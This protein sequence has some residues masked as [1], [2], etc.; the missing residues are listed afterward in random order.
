MKTILRSLT[1]AF[2]CVALVA[3]QAVAQPAAPKKPPAA[4]KK[5]QKKADKKDEKVAAEPAVVP[6]AEALTGEAKEAY[7]SGKL[8]YADGDYA[9]AKLK[10]E[11]AHELAQDPRLLW[12]MAAAEKQQRRYDRVLALV[13]RYLAEGGDKLTDA[14]RQ[15]AKSLVDMVRALVSEVT[16]SVNE[17]GAEVSVDG[18][19]IGESP[20]AAPL[21][22][23]QGERTFKVTKPGFR[24]FA[25]TQNLQGGTKLA[26]EVV[27]EPQLRE[28][29]LRV[30]A[31]VGD[32]IRIDGKVVGKGQWEGKLASGTHTL[33]VSGKGKRDHQTEIVI[34]DDQLRSERVT[35]E[36]VPK[37][38][39]PERDRDDSSGTWMFVSGGAA[40]AVGIGIAAYF[41]FRPEGETRTERASGTIP[42]NYVPLRF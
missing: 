40:L 42:P 10:F 13:E 24:P 27:L 19:K 17:P 2:L 8:L 5:D 35:L 20:L 4:A 7:E 11:R 26:L 15:E 1:A 6:L 34:E 29:R 32:T 30:V 31:G 23:T 16:V 12:N 28:G 25:K 37:A 3:P 36:A 14:D 33:S 21:T 22:L 9:G 38:G 41:L 18:E 39:P